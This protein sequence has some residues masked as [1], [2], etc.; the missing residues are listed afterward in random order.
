MTALEKVVKLFFC[1]DWKGFDAALSWFL[2]L[3]WYRNAST[4]NMFRTI[5][6]NVWQLLEKAQIFMKDAPKFPEKLL[7]SF[8]KA[9]KKLFEIALKFAF[10]FT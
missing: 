5:K 4:R 1:V 9:V 2:F 3:N 7:E 6:F 8:L 10:K